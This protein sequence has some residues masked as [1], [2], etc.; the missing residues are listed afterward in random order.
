MQEL[1]EEAIVRKARSV[2]RNRRIERATAFKNADRYRKRTG[3][4]PGAPSE[5]DP[6]WWSFHPHFDPAYCLRHA[7]YLSRTIWRKLQD[8]LYHP[9]PAIQFDVPK[10]D[11][12]ARKVM[13][14]AIPD[15]ALA[16]VIHRK[17]TKRNLNLFSRLSYGYRPDQNVFDAILNLSRSLDASKS[18]AVQYDF[19]K[20]FDTINHSYLKQILF[21]RQ[22]FLLP[23]AE[24]N[25][26]NAFLQ[27]KYDHVTTY[28]NNVFDVR[29]EGVPQGSSLSLFLSNA[30]AHELDLALE[31]LNG[32]FVRFAD[33]V[34]AIAHT[35]SDALAISGA[36]R[37]HCKSVGLRIN[38]EKSPGIL[39]FGGTPEREKRTFVI[40]TDDGDHVTTISGIDYLGHSVT[41]EGVR[42]PAKA[43]K[44]IKRRISSLI[45]KHLFLH[46]RGPT[47][48]LNAARVGAGFG[49]WDLVTCVNEVRKYIYGGLREA[50]IS[51]FLNDHSKPPYMR[52]LMGFFPLITNSNQLIELDGWLL[53][54]FRRAQRERVRVLAANFGVA[55][56]RLT[57]QE[58]L[59]GTWYN[60][61]L[62]ANDASL[63]SFVRAWRAARKYYRRYGL[64]GIE[65]PRY[66][67]LTDY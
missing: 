38:Y 31:K 36:F 3:L 45:H 46:R 20:Y 7:R 37:N 62:I 58:I 67:S 8:N 9:I 12:S 17:A 14:F 64:A 27:H 53:S 21:E 28:T 54:V 33:D 15:S 43:L 49:D 44:R 24:R 19:S 56:P 47:G 26:I 39:L 35:Y 13:A 52:G 4:A 42:I 25:A 60:Y 6:M 23:E 41:T 2:L 55:T 34:V 63:P 29:Q 5:A 48:A 30:A 61:P 40:D 57:K 22:L 16:N 66:Y 65:A 11:G 51:G 59:G 32:T 18:Y 50:H 10:P 1:I